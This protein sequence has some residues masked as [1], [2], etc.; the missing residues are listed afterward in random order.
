MEKIDN[1]TGLSAQDC[2]FFHTI[3]YRP[4]L[5]LVCLAGDPSTTALIRHGDQ[6][7]AGRGGGSSS[8]KD[9]MQ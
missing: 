3:A 4:Q 6:L 5:L 9:H 1:T 2:T 7:V 8:A